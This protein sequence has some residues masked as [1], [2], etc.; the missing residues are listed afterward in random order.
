MK[1]ERLVAHVSAIA[2]VEGENTVLQTEEDVAEK[3]TEDVM[4]EPEE[5]EEAKIKTEQ[6]G[7]IAI[8]SNLFVASYNL[9]SFF[10]CAKF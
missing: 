8:I 2:Q 5:I 9:I 3:I 1:V 7:K 4:V 6:I 10:I